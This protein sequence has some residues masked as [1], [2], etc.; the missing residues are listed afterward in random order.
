MAGGRARPEFH[1]KTL[2]RPELSTKR[3]LPKPDKLL[4]LV[5][6]WGKLFFLQSRV[7]FLCW[8]ASRGGGGEGG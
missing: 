2:L 1:M 7:P 8:Q 5:G 3:W 6:A 4:G